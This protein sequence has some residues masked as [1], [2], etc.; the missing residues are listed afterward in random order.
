VG[1]VFSSLGAC[2]SN[3]KRGLFFW[4]CGLWWWALREYF[5]SMVGLCDETVLD[6][7][8]ASIGLWRHPLRGPGKLDRW[9]AAYYSEGIGLFVGLS[10]RLI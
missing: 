5:K 4:G 10:S 2:L 9:L 8:H 7:V 6:D 3:R 1:S